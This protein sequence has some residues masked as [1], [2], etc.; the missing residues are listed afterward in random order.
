MDSW[1]DLIPICAGILLTAAAG[2][3]GMVAWAHRR[4]LLDTPN[5]RSSHT[6]P[7]PRGGGVALAAAF[8]AGLAAL[9]AAGALEAGTL[10]TLL[11]GLPIAIVGYIDDRV[12]LSARTRL[13]VQF[14]CA[15][16]LLWS[17]PAPIPAL[18]VLGYEL[19]PALAYAAYLLGL[20]W[21]TN[22]YN[23]MDGIDGIAAGQAI[24]AGLLWAAILPAAS[25]G[26]ALALAAAAL[27]F[28]L[29]NFPPARI[30][31]GDA[32][33]GFCGFIIGA[34]VLIQAQASATSP[35]LWLLPLA[36]FIADATLTLCVRVLRG[37]SPSQAHRSHA[38]QRLARRAGRHLP[39]SAGYFLLALLPVGGLFLWTARQAPDHAGAALI[40]AV[41]ALMIAA[42][43]FGAGRDDGH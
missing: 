42:A 39:V 24:A 36:P 30:F 15:A 10:A 14:A 6:R 22:L 38:Y 12:S 21:L 28:L 1:T 29:Y 25:A 23:F 26:P 41:A 16:A 17:L 40:A 43:C 7:T 20:L 37:Q 33:S 34:L 4:K 32:G 31:M 9:L 5:H 11:L 19:P 13:A 2:T 8:Y 35:L 18:A 27:G 3:R